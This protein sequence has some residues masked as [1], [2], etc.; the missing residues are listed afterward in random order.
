MFTTPQ[1]LIARRWK[2]DEPYF[3]LNKGARGAW[4]EALWG[5]RPGHRALELHWS[6]RA[7]SGPVSD[8]S[9]PSV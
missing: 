5:R 6:R 7:F 4:L 3:T 8:G 9:N 1:A 2:D